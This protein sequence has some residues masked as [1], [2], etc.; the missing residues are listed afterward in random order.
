[1]AR[2]AFPEIPRQRG[3]ATR[4]Q[5]IEA[6]W[7]ISSIRHAVQTTWQRPLPR[8]F[9]SHRGEL[10]AD[11][12]VVAAALWAGPSAVLTAGSAL[13]IYGGLDTPPRVATFV[14]SAASRSSVAPRAQRMRSVVPAVVAHRRGV[15]AVVSPGRALVDSARWDGLDTDEVQALTIACLQRS[16]TSPPLLKVALAAAGRRGQAGTTQGL[17][18]FTAGA[19]SLPEA[20]LHRLMSK[21]PGLPSFV[22]NHALHTP[23]G[24]RIGIPDAYLPSVGI[25]V[26]VHSRAHHSGID[27]AGHDRWS[28]TVEHDNAFAVHGVLVLGVTPQTLARAPKGFIRQLLAALESRRALPTPSVQLRCPDGCDSAVA[29]VSASS[30][31]SR[32]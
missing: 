27:E 23:D 30:H 24:R 12:L 9:A 2:R 10:D 7:T 19:W 4:P 25:A 16:V 26:Q 11:I 32:T 8:V 6:G 1:M 31:S 18:A 5:L 13:H 3:L 29:G 28:Q 22:L 14:V 17:A 15:V 20:T 21:T